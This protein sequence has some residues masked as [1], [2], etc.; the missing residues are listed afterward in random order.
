MEQ[1]CLTLHTIGANV[2][3]VL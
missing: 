3:A 2:C 1:A